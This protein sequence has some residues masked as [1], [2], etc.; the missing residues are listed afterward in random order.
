MPYFD[1]NATA[2]LHPTALATWRE[3]AEHGWHNPSSPYRAAARAHALLEQAREHIA[4]LIGGPAEDYVFTSGATEANN[5]VFSYFSRT[6]PATARVAVSAVEHPCVLEA[7]LRWF[8]GRVIVL[9]CDAQ[10]VVPPE[11]VQ[12]ALKG[13][14]VALVSLMA[15]NNETGALQP[16]RES[17][18]L[19][20]SAGVPFHCDAAQWLGKLPADGLADCDF[21]T[22]SA[23]KFGGPKGAGFL[24]IA[25]S[26]HSFHGQVGGEQERGRRAGTENLPG[27]CAMAAA[28]QTVIPRLAAEGAGWEGAR[29]LFE[30]G[31][32]RVL[33]GAEIVSPHVPRLWN[34]VM[35]LAPRHLNLRWVAALDQRGCQVSTGSACATGRAGPSHVLAA[36]GVPA[37]SAKR[38]LRV[39][40]GWDTTTADWEA[41]LA[42]LGEARAALDLDN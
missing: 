26:Q 3:A 5:A 7:A 40:A 10:G 2:P 33:P 9:P 38:A 18:A 16:W 24:K 17:L 34:T 14:N 12:D 13:G 19:C 36:M 21:L 41:L 15:A 42:A 31:L 29:K 39:S 32:H 30:G 8:P 11:S 4:A 35:F 25:A 6:A 1:Y 28:L 23:H 27:I 37:D 20:R 22:G